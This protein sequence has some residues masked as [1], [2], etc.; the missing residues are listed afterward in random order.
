[1]NRSVSQFTPFAENFYK[2]LEHVPTTMP[3]GTGKYV[4]CRPCT[5]Q[6]RHWQQMQIIGREFMHDCAVP[7]ILSAQVQERQGRT[8]MSPCHYC[9]LSLGDHARHQTQRLLPGSTH[10]LSSRP[11]KLFVFHPVLVKHGFHPVCSKP[12]RYLPLSAIIVDWGAAV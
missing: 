8:A 3:W 10:T 5:G 11:R 7:R 9:R 1:M 2:R 12:T 6:C 4:Y